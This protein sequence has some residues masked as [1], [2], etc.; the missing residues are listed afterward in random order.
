[1][2]GRHGTID[3]RAVRA[4]VIATSL[5]GLVGCS[6][7]G[8]TDNPDKPPQPDA[9]RPDAATPPDDAP[10]VDAPSIDACLTCAVMPSCQAMKQAVPSAPSGV[11]TI[12]PDGGGATAPFEVYCDMTT[13]L[14]GWTLVGRELLGTP[15]GDAG[16]LRYLGFDSL[17]ASAMAAGTQSGILGVR[18]GGMY[19]EVMIAWGARY[20]RFDKPPAF[21][22]FGNAVDASVNIGGFSTSEGLL[23]GWIN[24][25]GGAQLCVASR[26]MNVRPGD[27][28]WAIKPR[29]DNN[30]QCGCNSMGWVGRGAYYG[31][32]P[33]GQQ[34]VC[35]GWGGGWAG[36]RDNMVQKGGIAPTVE[37][38]IWIR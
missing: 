13:F 7:T 22:V 3:N 17:N 16:P 14:G 37:T 33:T 20:I 6:F 21:D 35:D 29:N 34:T 30:T 1:L 19:G 32:T 4:V 2:I 5:L 23:N 12:D 25:G 18:F 11:Y 10:M 36:V 38:R 27:T 24:M 8:A 26:A 31:G 9:P 15:A 28:S